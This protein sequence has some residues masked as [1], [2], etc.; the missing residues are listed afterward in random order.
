VRQKT[1]HLTG[2]SQRFEYRNAAGEVTGVVFEESAGR[3]RVL[4][5]PATEPLNGHLPDFETA[6]KFFHE[7]YDSE[8][9]KPL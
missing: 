4:V 8:T 2:M 9:G 6:W 1:A 5:P 7:F 3:F